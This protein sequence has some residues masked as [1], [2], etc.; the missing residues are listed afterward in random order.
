MDM[1]G[2]HFHSCKRHEHACK[3]HELLQVIDLREKRLGAEG[4]GD[5]VT[6]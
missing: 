2:R 3:E 6:C 1:D 4:D 5:L